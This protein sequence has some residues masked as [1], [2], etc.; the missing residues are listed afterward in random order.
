MILLNK[1]FHCK[2]KKKKNPGNFSSKGAQN[3]NKMSD[4][5]N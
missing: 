1:M 4:S 2:K 5:A 3:G